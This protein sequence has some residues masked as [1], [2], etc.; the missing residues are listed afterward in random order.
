MRTI[1]YII[2]RYSLIKIDWVTCTRPSLDY[3]ETV[4]HLLYLREENE[5]AKYR[6]VRR[7]TEEF[8]LSI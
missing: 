7:T 8:T 6:M 3:T 1:T 4:Q 2:Q 5:H